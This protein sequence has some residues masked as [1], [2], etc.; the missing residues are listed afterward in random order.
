M[1]GSRPHHPEGS[2]YLDQKGYVIVK[3][4]GH[5]RGD[6]YGWTYLHI[7]VAEKKYGIE[8]TRNFT[9]HHVNGDRSDNRPDNLELRW[10]NH[11]KGAD[12]LPA[13]L[14]LP[15]MRAIARAVLL[16]YDD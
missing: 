1:Q 8:I 13:L 7:L 3:A 15:E 11:G 16:Q 2:T 9:V 5:H 4:T 10:G 6:R 14:R 12:V